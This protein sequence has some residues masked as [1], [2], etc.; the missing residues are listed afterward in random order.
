MEILDNGRLIV[1]GGD[2]YEE[3][4]GGGAGG[5]IQIISPEGK[6]S[7]GSLSLGHGTSSYDISCNLQ[8][9]KNDHHGF[10]YLQGIST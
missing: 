6:L 3:A 1:Q 4:I 2:G 9:E 8:K 10:Y 7:A 5:I